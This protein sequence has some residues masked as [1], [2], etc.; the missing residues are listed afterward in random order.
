M[1]DMSSEEEEEEVEWEPELVMSFIEAWVVYI[2]LY[3]SYMCAASLSITN[4]TFWTWNWHCF[5]WNKE[6]QLNSCHL[7]IKESVCLLVSKWLCLI[8]LFF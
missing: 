4:T 8:F 1:S 5:A 7:Y 2:I 6:F 3:H